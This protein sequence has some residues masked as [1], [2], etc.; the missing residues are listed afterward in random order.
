M[1]DQI[2]LLVEQHR[3]PFHTPPHTYPH[4]HTSFM[5]YW[6][7]M[8]SEKRTSSSN[9]VARQTGLRA[10]RWLVRQRMTRAEP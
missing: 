9:S 3:P 8:F 4:I 7:S 10:L 2:R 1:V 5:G 6:K